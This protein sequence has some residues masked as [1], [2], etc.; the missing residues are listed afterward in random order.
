MQTYRMMKYVSFTISTHQMSSGKHKRILFTNNCKCGVPLESRL[1]AFHMDIT[2]CENILDSPLGA[3]YNHT[4][5]M[6]ACA[7]HMRHLSMNV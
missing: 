7:V 5:S 4:P 3:A 2:V 1:H 6:H